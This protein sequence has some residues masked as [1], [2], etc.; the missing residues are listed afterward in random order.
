MSKSAAAIME[1]ISEELHGTL[2]FKFS[3]GKSLDDFCQKYFTNYTKDRFEPLALRVFHKRKTIITLY[4]LDKGRNS[5]VDAVTEV[6]KMPVKKFKSTDVSLPRLMS[7]IS[8]LNFTL[9]A[10][11][12]PINNI[13]VINK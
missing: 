7:F 1:E 11:S 6:S 10:G 9:N 5:G 3:T 12:R 13:E 8:E 4:A 2:A